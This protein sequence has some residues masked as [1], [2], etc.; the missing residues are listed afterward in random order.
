MVNLNRGT[1][2][3]IGT[4]VFFFQFV[5]L[6]Y[7]QKMRVSSHAP[8][9]ADL[10]GISTENAGFSSL[11][12]ESGSISRHESMGS[13]IDNSID[14]K[15]YMVG[16]GDV[17][18][19]FSKVKADKFFLGTVNQNGDLQVPEL[20]EIPLGKIPLVKAKELIREYVQRK[21][22]TGDSVNVALYKVKY[23]T[24]CVAG[25][26][27]N[28]GT[29]EFEGTMHLWDVLRAAFRDFKEKSVKTTMQEV[30]LR[31]V[32]RTNRDSTG[33]FDL[34]SFIYKGEIAQNP[35]VYPGD[36]ITLFPAT[37]RVFI[38]G[39]I[40]GPLAG[41]VPIRAQDRAGNFISNFS[42]SENSDSGN[43]LLR[44]RLFQPD[45]SEKTAIINIFANP[46]EELANGDIINVPSKKNLLELQI[47]TIEGEVVRPGMYPIVKNGTKAEEVIVMAGGK[48]PFANNRNMVIIRR[49]KIGDDE[50]SLK[51]GKMTEVGAEISKVRPEL[52][53]A[54]GVMAS[55]NDF[56]VIRLGEHVETW[57]L[58][59]D[60]IMIPRSEKMVYISGSVRS[61]G[62]YPYVQGKN[63][64]FYIKCAGGFTEKANR[65]NIYLIAQ[66]G[67]VRQ[68]FN[69]EIV[70]DGNV[71]VVPLSQE[72]KRL[73][74][75]ALPIMN[76]V[77]STLGLLLGIYATIR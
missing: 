43:I 53:S 57:L 12:I 15:T 69:R 45:G 64:D 2:L 30:N 28:P 33:Y 77:I 73:T 18:S 5:P 27:D 31:S 32:R 48:T 71:I 25:I 29:F 24:V 61:P 50:A 37:N 11:S 62:G 3:I 41:W 72:Y 42:L 39:E 36:Q 47:V 63:K 49:K 46:E 75:I 70:E 8:M 65:S 10:E 56:S 34:F 58:P 67:K 22:R 7:A 55:T 68:V 21:L 52:G 76:A 74:T 6:S 44:R 59:G 14:E 17:F 20:G 4:L 13:T 9:G 54:L 1:R 40:S 19:I 66:Y 35:Y 60:N 26:A 38:H 23:A 51:E 16:G